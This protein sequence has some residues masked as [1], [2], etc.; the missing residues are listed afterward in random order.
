MK[1]PIRLQP[2]LTARLIDEVICQLPSG[3]EAD[4][5]VVASEGEIRC[6][7]VYKEANNRSFKQKTLYTEG[8]KVR[9]TRQARAMQNKSRYG[10]AEQESIWQNVEVEALFELAKAGVRVPKPHSI[11]EGV[12]LLE[13]ITDGE[14]NA[15]PRL[16]E[17]ALTGDQARRY[18]AILIR[19]MV[20]ML[21]AGYVHGDLSEFNVL[22]AHD[23]LVIIDLP[24]AVQATSNNAAAIF[25]RDLVHLTIFLGRFAPEL[26]DTKYA[27]E[28]W[29]IYENGKLRPKTKLT[30]LFQESTK[31]ADVAAVLAEIEEAREDAMERRKNPDPE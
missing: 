6:A 28:I 12:L 13:M 16:D 23:G 5:Y 25:E 30:G 7:K 31:K 8:R 1:V 3:K 11:Y 9:N 10:R 22:V 26:L 14:G 21:C 4:V 20:R 18:H 15:A 2:L 17:V 19:E 29:K 24:Q 27:K